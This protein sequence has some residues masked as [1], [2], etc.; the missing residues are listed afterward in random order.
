[1][2]VSIMFAPASMNHDAHAVS[3]HL[4]EAVA[5]W[6]VAFGQCKSPHVHYRPARAILLVGA[7]LPLAERGFERRHHVGDRFGFCFES[8]Q[9]PR[10]VWRAAK[11]LI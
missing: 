2:P 5:S 7:A 4:F 8:R 10:R 6:P 11:A 1:M 3:Q 9:R